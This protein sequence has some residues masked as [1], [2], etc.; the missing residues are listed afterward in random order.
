V[1]VAV[2]GLPASQQI[3][4]TQ[5]WAE[6]GLDSLMLVDLKNRLESMLRITLPVEK[7]VRDIDNRTLAAFI[8]QKLN[9]AG[10]PEAGSAPGSSAPMALDRVALSDDAIQELAMQI[11]QMFVT[12][13]KQRGRQILAGGRWRHDF[14][15][16][17]YLGLDFHPEVMAAIPAALAEWGVHPS[18]TRAVASP[19]LYDDLERE[20]AAFVGAPTTLVF[21]S[22]CS[23]S[24]CCRCWRGM[25]A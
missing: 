10:P 11:P 9:D 13:E 1:L 14:A 3:P 12:A 7:L 24:A 8:V 2:L 4:V 15:S 22:L 17:N 20:L 21:R 5:H 18:W 16:C 25:T 6:L 23:T 19:R